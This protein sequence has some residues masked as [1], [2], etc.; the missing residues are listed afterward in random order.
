MSLQTESVKSIGVKEFRENL[1]QY[2]HSDTPVAVTKHG[3]TV[4]YYLPARH[5]VKEEDKQALAAAAQKLNS[6]LEA[7]G[8]DPEDLINDFKELKEQHRQQKKDA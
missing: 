1:A 2:M 3:L 6:L 8:I 5:P 4:G 7:K